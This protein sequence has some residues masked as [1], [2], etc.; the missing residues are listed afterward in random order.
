MVVLAKSSSYRR[1]LSAVTLQ[2][3]FWPSLPSLAGTTLRLSLQ[4]MW[5]GSLGGSAAEPLSQVLI[6]GS[7]D[8]VPHWAPRRESAS[9]SYCVSAS[10][11]QE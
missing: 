6:P 4:L 8:R 7:L 1:E 10:L 2:I 5:L 11:S 3:A 9:P